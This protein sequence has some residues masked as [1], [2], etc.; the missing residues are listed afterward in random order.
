MSAAPDERRELAIFI[1][2]GAGE[3]TMMLS[4]LPDGRV[5]VREWS[6]DGD[7]SAGLARTATPREM[8]ELLADVERRRCVVRPPVATIRAWLESSATRE[9]RR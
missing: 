9:E 4:P 6:S 3:R 2:D 7:L 5:A 8:S 1:R